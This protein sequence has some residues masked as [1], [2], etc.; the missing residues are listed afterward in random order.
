VS[1]KGG[2]VEFAKDLEK[3]GFDILASGGTH[4]ILSTAKVKSNLIQD[5]TQFP[6]ILGGR[7]KTLHPKIFGGILANRDNKNHLKELEEFDIPSIDLVI[8][9]LYPFKEKPGIENIDIGGVALIRAAGKNHKYVACVTRPDQYETVIDELNKYGAVQPETK[10]KFP[11]EAFLYTAQF[12]SMIAEF[13]GTDKLNLIYEKAIDLRYGE[14]AHQ[15]SSLY[16]EVGYKGTTILDAKK[17]QGKELSF[18][19][20][21]DTDAA[22]SSKAASVPILVV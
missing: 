13:L 1:D 3:H 10:L 7:V 19:N 17:L 20:L 21:N 14:N 22:T 9:N 16:K 11:K 18:N 8:C 2:I 6:E 4:K 15:T 5:I 12:D